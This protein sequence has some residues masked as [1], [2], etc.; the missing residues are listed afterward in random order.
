M[1]SVPSWK[2]VRVICS[3]PGISSY[4]S[5]KFV[6]VGRRVYVPGASVI[7]CAFAT[8]LP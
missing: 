8:G 4:P 7:D 5:R 6:G 3:L 2:T 1:L